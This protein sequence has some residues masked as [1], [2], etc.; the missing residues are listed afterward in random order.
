MELLVG[1]DDDISARGSIFLDD[2]ERI[3]TVA[4]GLYFYGDLEMRENLLRMTVVHDDSQATNGLHFERI[5]VLGF[6]EG[7][8]SIIVNGDDYADWAFSDGAV[9]IN[10]LALQINDNFEVLFV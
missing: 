2:G 1:L 4:D 5:I 8:T 10:N 9:F 6:R 7:I 3:D